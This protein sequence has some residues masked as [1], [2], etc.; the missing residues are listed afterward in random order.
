M[1]FRANTV[2]PLHFIGFEPNFI[3]KHN[4]VVGYLPS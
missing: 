4:M 3:Q 2:R 1:I